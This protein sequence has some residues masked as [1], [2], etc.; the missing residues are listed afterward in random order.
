MTARAPFTQ[1]DV[2]RAVLA[3]I[4][5]GMNV[6]SVRVLPGGT[7]EVCVNNSTPSPVP[8]ENALDWKFYGEQT[9]RE[10]AE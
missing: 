8:K 9:Q 2:K 1:H 7:I 10:T 3:C 5:A 6:S 4:G